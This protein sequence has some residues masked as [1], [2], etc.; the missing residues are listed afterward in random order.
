[1]YQKV[2]KYLSVFAIPAFAVVSFLGHGWWAFALPLLTF[3][4]VPLAE[5]FTSSSTENF[6]EEQEV[7]AL[8]DK[9]Y[10]RLLYLM[11]PLQFIVIFIGLYLFNN[12]ESFM[13]N[14]DIVSQA[15]Q[16][17]QHDYISG[18]GWNAR[19]PFGAE[20]MYLIGDLSMVTWASWTKFEIVGKIFAMGICCGVIGI[21]LGHELGHRLSTFERFLAKSLLL[22]SMYMHFIIEHNRGHH[23]RVATDEDPAS[24]RRG[25]ILYLFWIRSIITGY[26]SAWHLEIEKLKKSNTPIISLKNEMI[27][28][29]LIQTGFVALIFFV[30]GL[31]GAIFFL[32][33]AL[34]GG[35]LLETVNYIEHYGL[36]RTF[37]KETQQYE[38]VFPTHSW[39][40]N[41]KLGR[42]FLFELTRHSDHHY[43]AKRKFQILR[44]FD[45]SPQMPLG[46][47]SMMV[48]STVPPLW[49]FIM[50]RHIE[51]HKTLLA[52]RNRFSAVNA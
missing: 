38:K 2:T 32:I 43:I 7:K 8:E 18:I 42:L 45:E 25:E 9:F 23:N 49:F 48:L 21:N 10:D 47:P 20:P 50:H 31:K 44:H 17:L 22:S 24:A 6:S 15:V 4:Y 35:L 46:Y 11:V 39:N 33:A 16:P 37:N 30:F 28:F 41:H 3:V 19:L 13:I 27:Q 5:L 52:A 51:T 29:I 36:R 34:I 12:P 14:L 40:S 1:M 26:I